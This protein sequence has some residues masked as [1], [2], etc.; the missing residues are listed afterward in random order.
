[1]RIKNIFHSREMILLYHRIA[2]SESD[3]WSLCVTPEHFAEHVDVL[4]KYS[5]I[6]LTD[7]QS[8]G[9]MF[10]RSG[11][12][13][14]IT[15]DDGYAD[16]FYQAAP[17]LDRYGMPATFFIVTG[18]V[19]TD[20]EFWWDEL[21]KIV[22]QTTVPPTN[23]EFNV[24][25]ST[26]SF[27]VGSMSSPL[28]LY[29]SLYDF[30]QPLSHELRLGLMD[31]LLERSKQSISVRP[32]YQVM[33]RD[34]IRQLAGNPLFAIGAHTVTHPRLST[35]SIPV[36]KTEML[37]SKKWLEELVGNPIISFSYP[38]GGKVHYTEETLQIVRATGFKYACTNDGRYVTKDNAPLELPR[39][40]ITDMDGEEF[41]KLLFY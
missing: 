30:L 5:T 38:Y 2:R 25:G 19:E 12:S 15:F 13:V 4:R 23:I 21:E 34:E 33:T 31:Q 14:A 7:I 3:P 6:R 17:L 8:A 36:Q 18:Y 24:L 37:D 16:N 39:F 32:P 41:E 9:R 27:D 11:Y 22:F 35:Q 1:M 28:A 26:Y 10:G 29:L 20:R 40:N